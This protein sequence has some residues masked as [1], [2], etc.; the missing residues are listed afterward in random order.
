[1]SPPLS[2]R[3][4]RLGSPGR[5]RTSDQVGSAS[6]TIE[7]T[8]PLPFL[9]RLRD[10]AFLE[11]LYR[12]RHLS[13][14]EISRVDDVNRSV[15]LEALERFCMARNSNGHKHPDQLPFGYDDLNCR[16]V[17]N[18]AEHEANNLPQIAMYR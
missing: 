15:V 4:C 3:L 10:R 9:L 2:R 14:R 5:T 12:Q 18:K 8:L 13:P 16:L 11:Q 17:N 7:D 6:R 1:V